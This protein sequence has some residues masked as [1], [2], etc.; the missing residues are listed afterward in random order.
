[1][2]GTILVPL[3]AH[4]RSPRQPS[5]RP[6]PE[7][8]LSAQGAAALL[9][10]TV[11]ADRV[12]EPVNSTGSDVTVIPAPASSSGARTASPRFCGKSWRHRH[13]KMADRAQCPPTKG[14]ANGQTFVTGRVTAA[15][16][17]DETGTNLRAAFGDGAK[18]P[19]L[20]QRCSIYVRAENLTDTKYE[21]TGNY[22]TPGLSIYAGL[23]A[24]F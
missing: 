14:A 5:R 3:F 12:D 1:L 20:F 17:I 15:Y 22:G 23:T 19:T 6:S 7:A 4:Y 16:H 24:K 10:I 8:Y 21:L 18:V 13:P 11:T 9:A 2:M